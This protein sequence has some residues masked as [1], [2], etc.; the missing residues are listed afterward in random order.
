MTITCKIKRMRSIHNIF[1]LVRLITQTT[2]SF[3]SI[4]WVPI[5]NLMLWN[6]IWLFF[7]LVATPSWPLESSLHLC[8]LMANPLSIVFPR[9]PFSLTPWV[10]FYQVSPGSS[11]FYFYKTLLAQTS[12]LSQVT[13]GLN[14]FFFWIT[15]TPSY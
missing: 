14:E 5:S 12:I 2:S 3:Q 10:L 6:T 13:F 8:P 11:Q 1:I 9:S 4:D 15:T 7:W